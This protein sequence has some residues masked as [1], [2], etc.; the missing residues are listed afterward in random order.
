VSY[1]TEKIVVL[2]AGCGVKNG[3]EIH[4]ATLTLYFLSKHGADYLWS[5]G[6]RSWGWLVQKKRYRDFSAEERN[7]IAPFA[8]DRQFLI[9]S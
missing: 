7:E 5:Y 9:D 6:H 4:E 2:L 8:D 3:S 1:E